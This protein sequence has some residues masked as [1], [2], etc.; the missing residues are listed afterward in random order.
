MCWENLTLDPKKGKWEIPETK[1]GEKQEAIL[2]PQLVELLK[3]HPGKAEK[4]WVFPSRSKS[5]RVEEIK[6]AWE[7]VREVSGLHHLQARDLRR[8]TASWA[9]DNNV[10]IAFMQ[11]QLGHSSYATTAEHYTSILEDAVRTAMET[12]VASM[13]QAATK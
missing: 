2:T 1:T 11:T 9:Q 8:T 6:K 10:P 5:G 12:T 3:Q 4:G 13:I 7:T